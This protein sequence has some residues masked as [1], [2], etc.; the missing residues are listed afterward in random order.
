MLLEMCVLA[1]PEMLRISSFKIPRVYKYCAV[2]DM[3][4]GPSVLAKSLSALYKLKP[5]LMKKASL[6]L[7][8]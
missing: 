7:K 8:S 2:L 5:F 4:T 6:F 1:V 3:E